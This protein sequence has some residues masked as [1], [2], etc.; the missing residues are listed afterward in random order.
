MWI[1]FI[2]LVEQIKDKKDIREMVQI[3]E[4]SN[5]FIRS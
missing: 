1:Q 3:I 4:Y 2:Y 5:V